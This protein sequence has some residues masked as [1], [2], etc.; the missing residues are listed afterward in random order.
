ME[1]INNHYEVQGIRLDDLA[2]KYN[3][4]L[5]IYDAGKME[6]QYQKMKNAFA[7][8]NMKINYACKALTNINVLKF[9]K[10]IGA[11]LDTVSLQ[12]VTFGLKAGFAP[13]DIIYT[14]LCWFR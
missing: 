8:T 5:Y 14:K 2:E 9:F 11:G 6:R 10:N 12:E 13:G 7:D 4:P 1:L 3:A